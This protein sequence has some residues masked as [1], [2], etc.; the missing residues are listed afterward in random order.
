MLVLSEKT[1]MGKV[2]ASF[3]ALV[4]MSTPPL[5]QIQGLTISENNA[6]QT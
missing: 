1:A 5:I 3:A 6:R 2:I 4:I